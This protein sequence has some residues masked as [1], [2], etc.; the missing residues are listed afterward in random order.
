AA[1]EQG[2]ARSGLR[3][4]P[5][6]EYRPRTVEGAVQALP[7]ANLAII[8]TPGAYAAG[9]ARKALDLGLHVLMFSDNVSLD[10]EVA[11]KGQAIA[12]GLYMLGPDCGTAII[13]G[14]PLGFANAVPSGGVGL[15]SASGSG[16]QQ[17]TC[18][19]AESGVG[20]SH[21]LGVGG[22][23]LSEAVGGA[24]MV[25]GLKA[26]QADSSTEVIVV[27][28]KPPAGTARDR[29]MAELKQSPKPCVVAFL[30]ET[31]GGGGD[32]RI[33]TEETLEGAARRVVNLVRGEEPAWS[34]IKGSTW[35]RLQSLSA[36]LPPGARAIRGMYSGGTLCYEGLLLLRGLGHQVNS[37]LDSKARGQPGPAQ[38]G[39]THTLVD[40]GG[41]EYTVGR[42]H[43]MIDFRLRC[44]QI[45]EAA[46]PEVGVLLLDVILGYGAH[47]DPAAELA[48]ALKE[49]QRRAKDR[50]RV[51]ACVVTLC[52][53]QEDPQG[54]SRQE[55]ALE[56]AG[57]VVV[58][59]NALAVRIVSALSL[60]DLS[61]LPR[62]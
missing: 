48:P 3:Q 4:G 45:V 60:G 30:G 52:G 10:D 5:G 16:L 42:P 26:L 35:K 58:H 22:R 9:E 31:G 40:L 21:G 41:D 34:S 12:R 32:G 61:V 36:D 47:P 38:S 55:E 59:S 7:G 29:V 15:V 33:F 28:S 54:L 43:P 46:A 13:N 25:E 17:V 39:P 57:A 56:E 6:T 11:L 1:M 44:Q 18:L 27:I 23:D 53:T 14:V 19:L 62:R 20:I 8:S 49:A 50:G 24:M 51:L 37:N 2:L